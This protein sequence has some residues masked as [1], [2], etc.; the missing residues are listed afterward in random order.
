MFGDSVQRLGGSFRRKRSTSRRYYFHRI[1]SY[2]S[3]NFA[4]KNVLLVPDNRSEPKDLLCNCTNAKVHI[5][6]RWS[7]EFRQ[8]T[9]RRVVDDLHR[10]T[11]LSEELFVRLRRHVGMGISVHGDVATHV[12]S[13]K[14]I[15]RSLEDGKSDHEVG[16]FLVVGLE[17]LV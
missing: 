17:E 7:P 10:P 2:S 12:E 16:R 15:G 8:V 5:T 6:I 1:S 13:F 11:E 14:E 9:T 4:K 3:G